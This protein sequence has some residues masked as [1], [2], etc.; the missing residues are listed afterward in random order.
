MT[1]SSLHEVQLITTGKGPIMNKANR[2]QEIIRLGQQ[3]ARLTRQVAQKVAA[4]ATRHAKIAQPVIQR[5][6]AR[7]WAE[8]QKR[9][10]QTQ[11]LLVRA[12]GDA[13]VNVRG[14]S[15]NACIA[16]GCMWHQ[17]SPRAQRRILVITG[18]MGIASLVMAWPGLVPNGVNEN[19]NQG[20]A[21][22]QGVSI[23]PQVADSTW[24]HISKVLPLGFV[25]QNSSTEEP[26]EIQ[27]EN[28]LR[29]QLEQARLDSQAA[30]AEYDFAVQQWNAEL[31]ACQSSAT[32]AGY[33]SNQMGRFAAMG[34]QMQSQPLRQP[35]Q[36]LREA[37][38]QAELRYRL[39]SD[40]YDRLIQNR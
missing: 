40:N 38:F 24:E 20:V 2:T 37:A 34:I 9:L 8:L 30:A 1:L 32:T 14:F 36:A 33:T 21:K 35:N 18:V 7:A 39:A 5:T 6:S 19:Q 11:P 26:T 29:F 17:L 28:E 4:E 13:A 23:D 31:A 25:E 12:M 10:R 22:N 16:F 27:P 15:R 3:T